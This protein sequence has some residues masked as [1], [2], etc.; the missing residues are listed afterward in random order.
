MSCLASTY[1][2][3]ALQQ[4]VCHEL[5]RP[6]SASLWFCHVPW[7]LEYRSQDVDATEKSDLETCLTRVSTPRPAPLLN[8]VMPRCLLD[9]VIARGRGTT[10][11]ALGGFVV[12]HGENRTL[13]T[14]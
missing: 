8:T 13:Q 10:V 14:P 4:P 5:S 9:R 2:L 11:S 3:L 1:E 6:D 7:I 12:S